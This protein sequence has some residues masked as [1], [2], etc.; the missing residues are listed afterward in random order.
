MEEKFVNIV[1]KLQSVLFCTF[2][3]VMESLENKQ[4]RFNIMDGEGCGWFT[5]QYMRFF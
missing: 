3:K 2:P 5:I 1:S 4:R